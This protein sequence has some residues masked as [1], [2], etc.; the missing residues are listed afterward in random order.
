[1]QAYLLPKRLAVSQLISNWRRERKRRQRSEYYAKIQEES[2][3]SDGG[4]APGEHDWTQLYNDDYEGW[5]AMREG[6]A[7]I[8]ASAKERGARAAVVLFCDVR[9]I[10]RYVEYSHPKIAPL[11][12]AVVEDAGITFI[13][14]KGIFAPYAGRETEIGLG[15][16]IGAAH[17][18]PN[19]PLAFSV[20]TSFWSPKSAG[21]TTAKTPVWRLGKKCVG[22]P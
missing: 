8:A 3:V 2:G 12:R 17:L 14:L 10:R 19:A 21:T 4:F 1:M 18:S 22:W 7:S 15:G 5:R 6:F 11:I 16:R 9:D 13:D 20:Q